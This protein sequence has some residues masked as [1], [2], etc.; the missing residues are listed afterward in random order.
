[1]AKYLSSHTLT[2]NIYYDYDSST[3]GQTLTITPGATDPEQWRIF[4]SQ[5]KCQAFQISLQ[6]NA[7][8]GAGFTMSGIDLVVGVKK[9]YTVIPSARSAAT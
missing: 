1:M 4:L 9:G 7:S 8:T 2:I 5:Q 3:I 6:E